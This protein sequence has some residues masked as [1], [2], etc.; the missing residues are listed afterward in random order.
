MNCGQYLLA[1]LAVAVSG[2]AAIFELDLGPVN[3][4]GAG[5]HGAN[6]T[7]P[8]ATFGSGGEMNTRDPLAAG[9]SY[10]ST[11]KVLSLSIGWGEEY[12]FTDLSGIPTMLEIGGPVSVHGTEGNSIY[13]IYPS[14]PGF[15][16]ES[17]RAG[18][19]IYDI[20]LE[21][22][23]LGN[24]YALDQQESDLLG[25]LWY[26]NLRTTSFAGGE[27]RGQMQLTPVPEPETYALM[28][29]LGLVGF[30]AYRRYRLRP[31]A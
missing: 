6:Y 17:T 10:N 31:S 11:T 5:I 16:G 4:S 8:R 26:L 24:S 9:I 22:T 20:P 7:N 2:Q 28:A 12:G 29:G 25:G 13:A 1:A 14:H 23:P 18:T 19:F 3:G 27:I 21:P 30:A 15:I